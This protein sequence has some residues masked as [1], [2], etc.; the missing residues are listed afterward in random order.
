LEVIVDRILRRAK[1]N[2]GLITTTVLTCI[3]SNATMPEQYISVVLPGRMY[4]SA[5]KNRG[6][7]PKQLSSTLEA[8]GTVT[9]P[10]IPWN[11]CGAFLYGVL[12]VT[13]WEYGRYAVFNYM[14]P[15]ITVVF[16]FLGLFI[17]KLEDAP[18]TVVGSE[19]VEA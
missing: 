18:D 3:A 7:H 8:A 5:Y 2:G 14:M 4:H 11:T 17:Y 6:L 15:L 10:L 16:A 13:A 19:H 1:S 9:S 12:G